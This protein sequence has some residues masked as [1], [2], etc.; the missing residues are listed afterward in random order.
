[1]G[2]TSAVPNADDLAL[3]EEL[4]AALGLLRRHAR[5]SA[6][7][8]WPLTTGLTGSQV[9][10]LRLIRRQPETSVADA[11]AELGLAANTVSTLV[12][13]LTELRL[14]RRIADPAD[15]RVARLTLTAAARRRVEAWRDRR[16]ALAAHALGELAAGDREA[17][18]SAL[19]ALTRLAERLAA[20]A[21]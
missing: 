1:M 4:F 20:A 6:G 16:A 7:Q 10:L 3:A 13:Q 21:R 17:I 18:E 12:G 2:V 8:P 15:R 19:P 9:E 14:L 5:R 11:A